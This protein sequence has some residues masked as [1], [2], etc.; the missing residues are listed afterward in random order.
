MALDGRGAARV[1]DVG[2][3]AGAQEERAGVGLLLAPMEG[4]GVVAPVALVRVGAVGEEQD[5]QVA[6]PG[7]C[8]DGEREGRVGA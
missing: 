6:V 7:L 8:V 5:G 1:A 4:D 3:C 2:V